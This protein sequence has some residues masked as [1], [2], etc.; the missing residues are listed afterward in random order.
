MGTSAD[1]TNRGWWRRN[2]W[3]LVALVPALVA[4]LALSTEDLYYKVYVREPRVPVAAAADGSY[5][6]RGTRVRLVDFAKATDLKTYDGSAFEPPAGVVIWRARIEFA[7]A[8]GI[9]PKTDAQKDTEIGGCEISLIDAEGRIFEDDPYNMLSGAR[10]VVGS[11]CLVNF[12]APDPARYV[13]AVYFALPSDSQPVAVRI[14]D[15]IMLPNYIRLT[16]G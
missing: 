10:D 1:F 13:N 2:R 8:P 15:A 11:G 6:V 3:G 4:L 12:D 14:Y 9:D 16:P 5:E 7:V